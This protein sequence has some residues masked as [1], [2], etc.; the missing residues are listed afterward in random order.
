MHIASSAIAKCEA[1]ALGDTVAPVSCTWVRAQHREN[2]VLCVGGLGKHPNSD[3]EAVSPDSTS[4]SYCGKAKQ[5]QIEHLRWELAV[6][7]HGP[8]PI[9]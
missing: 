3:S 6:G 9:H 2:A 7:T 8:A 4:H 5:S 1:S